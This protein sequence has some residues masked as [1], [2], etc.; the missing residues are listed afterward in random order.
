MNDAKKIVIA[1]DLDK[2]L[3]HYETWGDGEIGK[4]VPAMLAQVKEWIALGYEVRILTAR[5]ADL[6][7]NVVSTKGIPNI[8]RSDTMLQWIKIHE[9]V[10]KHVGQELEITA[11]KSQDITEIWDDRAVRVEA[12]TGV[13]ELHDAHARLS[14]A[15][16]SPGPLPQRMREMIDLYVTAHVEMER[17]CGQLSDQEDEYYRDGGIS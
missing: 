13:S 16:I 9:W 14:A 12:N 11:V 17:L 8:S 5:V 2:T 6:F 3:A 15:G 1:V 4:P 7:A 10:L